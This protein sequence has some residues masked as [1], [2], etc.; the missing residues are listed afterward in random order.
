[1]ENYKE[2][3]QKVIDASLLIQ[4]KG[5]IRGTSGN[6]SLRSEDK[7]VIAITPSSIEYEEL[8]WEMIPLVDENG[9]VLDI[10]ANEYVIKNKLKPSSEVLM[11]TAV[12]KARP[13]VASVV[14][15]HSKYSTLLSHMGQR[16]PIMTIPMISYFPD[17]APIVPFEFPGSQAL[18]DAAVKGL[19]E[20]GSA[21]ILEKHGLLTAG[22]T[23]EKALTCTEYIEEGAEYAYCL[24]AAGLPVEGIDPEKIMEMI[25]ILMSGRAL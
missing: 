5:L 7:A 24:R 17:P 11:H 23:L 13:D 12:L 1:M 22:K 21:V 10:P 8:T 4:R 20:R 19:G 9:A 14:H 25:K 2:L 6:I 15:T 3:R 18:A 16:L